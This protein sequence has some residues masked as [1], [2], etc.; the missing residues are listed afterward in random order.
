VAFINAVHKKASMAEC[1]MNKYDKL[2]YHMMYSMCLV[3][4]VHPTMYTIDA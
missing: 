4:V 3:H 1:L 2:L